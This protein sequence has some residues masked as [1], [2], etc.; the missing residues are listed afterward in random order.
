M[1]ITNY[2]GTISLDFRIKK[3]WVLICGRQEKY[4]IKTLE[5]KK[6]F[7]IMKVFFIF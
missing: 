4:K 5:N 6:D 3:T 7:Q 2:L 1:D